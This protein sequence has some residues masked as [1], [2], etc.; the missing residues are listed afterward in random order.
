MIGK[1][2]A[3]AW[4]VAS[5]NVRT[6]SNEFESEEESVMESERVSVKERKERCPKFSA[7]FLMRLCRK[8]SSIKL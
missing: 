2:C 6:N 4:M 5:V 3:G 1:V 8:K 7:N